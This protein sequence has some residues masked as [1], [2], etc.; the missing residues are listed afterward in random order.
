VFALL[1]HDFIL[2]SR[3]SLNI[4]ESAAIQL[5][6]VDDNLNKSYEEFDDEILDPTFVIG[7]YINMD[8]MD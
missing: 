2:Q 5:E 1:D 8:S 7:N 6:N 3:S 4:I